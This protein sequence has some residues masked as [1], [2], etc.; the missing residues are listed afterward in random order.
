MADKD[1]NAIRK[2]SDL[3]KAVVIL[4]ALLKYSL[5]YISDVT[6]KYLSKVDGYFFL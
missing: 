5:K 3:H 6:L 1:G 2:G 4:K